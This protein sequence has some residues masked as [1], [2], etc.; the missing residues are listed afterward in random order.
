MVHVALSFLFALVGTTDKPMKYDE[1]FKKADKEKKPLVILVGAKWCA[2][3]Q[4]MKRETMNP[5]K[6]SG[7]LKKVVV[8]YVDKDE[9]PELAEK[10]MRGQTL[11]QVVVYSKKEGKWKR[12][13]VTGMQS[14][15]RMRELLGRATS[16]SYTQQIVR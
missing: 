8:T 4:I 6:E 14:E 1:A 3:C 10:L 11:P 9:Q 5:M 12:Y 13:S 7:A 16:G 2:S 15:K